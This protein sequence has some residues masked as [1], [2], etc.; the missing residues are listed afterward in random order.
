MIFFLFFLRVTPNQSLFFAAQASWFYI[1]S[2]QNP[3][4]SQETEDK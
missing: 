3:S 2:L 4:E 1:H